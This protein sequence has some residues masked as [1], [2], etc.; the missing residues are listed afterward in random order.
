MDG[1]EKKTQAEDKDRLK[2][3]DHGKSK[4]RP[5]GIISVDPEKRKDEDKGDEKVQQTGDDSG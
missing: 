4:I 5:L 1:T 3:N 2:E